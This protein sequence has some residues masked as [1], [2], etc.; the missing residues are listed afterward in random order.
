M[1][2]IEDRLSRVFSLAE[3]MNELAPANLGFW[4]EDARDIWIFSDG[5]KIGGISISYFN[6]KPEWYIKVDYDDGIHYMNNEEIRGRDLS[7]NGAAGRALEIVENLIAEYQR[8]V[9]RKFIK[10]QWRVKC[11]KIVAKALGV[12]EEAI[13]YKA[14]HHVFE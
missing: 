13:E 7:A 12:G 8:K 6:M 2:G 14:W 4:V 5:E 10:A 3:Q 1:M 9:A 11:T